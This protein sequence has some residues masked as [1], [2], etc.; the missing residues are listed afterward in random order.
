MS[1]TSLV[2]AVLAVLCSFSLLTPRPTIAVTA[3]CSCSCSYLDVNGN[4][5]TKPQTDHFNPL[6]WVEAQSTCQSKCEYLVGESGKVTSVS[7]S[8][9]PAPIQ[10]KCKGGASAQAFDQKSC[11]AACTTAAVASTAGQGWLIPN[12]DFR[13]VFGNVI[14]A[15]LGIIGSIAF[16]MIIYGGFLYLTSAGAPETITKA[17]NIVVWAA[18]GLAVIFAAYAI[19]ETLF[20]ISAGAAG[21]N[22]LGSPN[23]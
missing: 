23:P 10:C 16:A 1:R 17:K 20:Q 4:A 14:K 11:P 3:D 6:S 7:P 19:V 15:M 2:V 22:L 5:L 8:C 12:P 9:T 21:A 13:D 18:L